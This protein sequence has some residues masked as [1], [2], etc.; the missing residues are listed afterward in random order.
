[1]KKDQ[2]NKTNVERVYRQWPLAWE[3]GL[4][5]SGID[6]WLFWEWVWCSCIS[7]TSMLW[8]WSRVEVEG[9]EWRQKGSEVGRGGQRRGREV[10]PWQPVTAKS[11]QNCTFPT[12]HPIHLLPQHDDRTQ[13]YH[14]PMLH[15]HLCP[16]IGW[17]GYVHK[18]CLHLKAQTGDLPAPLP[19]TSP[20]HW[21]NSKWEWVHHRRPYLGMD[22]TWRRHAL[23]LQTLGNCHTSDAMIFIHVHQIHIRSD[24]IIW[25]G[26]TG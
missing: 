20:Q 7:C 22:N 8:S 23:Q 14:L 6:L 16:W 10:V 5:R 2:A 15:F 17:N 18:L 13:V 3:P 12:L 11:G 9:A 26:V 21:W 1:M 4:N 24:H 19:N 25:P